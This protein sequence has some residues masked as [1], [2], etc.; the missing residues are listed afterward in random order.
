MQT[1]APAATSEIE[2]RVATAP[3]GTR[4]VALLNG[5]DAVMLVTPAVA[6]R[7][8]QALLE[9]ADEIEGVKRS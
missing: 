1:P 9:D 8:A 6:R 2:V 3:D 5:G 7:L 4:F